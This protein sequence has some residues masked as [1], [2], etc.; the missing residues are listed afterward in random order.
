MLTST[1]MLMLCQ[2]YLCYSSGTRHLL[3][4]SIAC[5]KMSNGFAFGRKRS[6]CSGSSRPR[7]AIVVSSF[8]LP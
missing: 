3:P 7:L 1:S 8:V 2:L 4:K 5:S 6:S